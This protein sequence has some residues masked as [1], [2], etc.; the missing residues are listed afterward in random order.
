MVGIVAG[1]ERKGFIRR[2]SSKVSA[3]AIDATV[4]AA[5]K[6]VYAEAVRMIR[7]VDDVLAKEFTDD[8]LDQF[9]D[10]LERTI[11]AMRQRP[12]PRRRLTSGRADPLSGTRRSI[13]S[14]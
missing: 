3:R 6:S 10:F 8:E 5:G 1:L 12:A 2:K 13:C 14:S 7:N 9:D 11:A 4:T